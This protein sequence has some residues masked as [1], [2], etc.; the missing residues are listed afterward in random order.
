[1]RIKKG[2]ELRKICNE[3][4]IISKGKENIDFSKIISF[5]E[6]TSYLWKNV[7]G[8][9]YTVEMLADLLTQEYEVDQATALKDAAEI[10]REWIKVGIAEE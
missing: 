7:I 1:M 4:L 6:S 5:N 9:E 2:F 10:A 8:K 3:D